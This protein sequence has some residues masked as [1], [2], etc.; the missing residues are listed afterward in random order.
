MVSVDQKDRGQGASGHL[1]WQPAAEHEVSVCSARNV[2]DAIDKVWGRLPHPLIPNLGKSE[3]LSE[4][5]QL[6]SPLGYLLCII[7]T[8]SDRAYFLH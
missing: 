4:L 1:P 2:Y 5:T 3:R 8:Y 6:P 7:T